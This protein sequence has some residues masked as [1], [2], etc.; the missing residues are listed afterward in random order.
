MGRATNSPSFFRSTICRSRLTRERLS[1]SGGRDWAWAG[2]LAGIAARA[3][4][5]SV[6]ASRT[7]LLPGRRVDL[8]LKSFTSLR[9]A[10]NRWF[11]AAAKECDQ[12]DL[13]RKLPMGVTNFDNP[14]KALCNR[15]LPCC[16]GGVQEIEFGGGAV[17][18]V[19]SK[20]KQGEITPLQ[21]VTSEHLEL[22]AGSGLKAGNARD[23]G[24]RAPGSTGPP[25]GKSLRNR[26]GCAGALRA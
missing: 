7:S 6:A 4:S 5:S 10:A 1:V 9:F 24:V 25:V 12:P 18:G 15:P 22:R 3:A 23:V 11:A 8:S 19:V 13:G 20:L 16:S 26:R 17:R 14:Y 2:P 21:D